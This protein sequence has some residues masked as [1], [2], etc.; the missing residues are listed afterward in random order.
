MTFYLG[1]GL[2]IEQ[3]KYTKGGGEHD[4]VRASQSC[5]YRI[6]MLI[7]SGQSSP[8]SFFCITEDIASGLT[9]FSSLRAFHSVPWRIQ[10]LDF[11]KKMNTLPNK[12]Y[13]RSQ[14][15]HNLS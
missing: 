15:G 9:G 2:L 13:S 3:K 1:P 7:A 4:F 11:I 12:S 5:F 6:M 8:L 14:I 10:H